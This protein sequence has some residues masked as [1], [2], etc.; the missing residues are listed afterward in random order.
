MPHLQ[1]FKKELPATEAE[2]TAQ[3]V[4]ALAMQGGKTGLWI[5]SILVNKPLAG[6]VTHM[7]L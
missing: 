2:E 7:L 6:V 1:S 5:S 3:Q 4:K